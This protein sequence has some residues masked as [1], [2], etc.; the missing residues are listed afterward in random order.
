MWAEEC[1]NGPSRL[2]AVYTASGSESANARRLILSAQKQ[3]D[4][5]ELVASPLA[6]S[7]GT[8]PNLSV[9]GCQKNMNTSKTKYI[10]HFVSSALCGVLFYRSCVVSFAEFKSP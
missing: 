1:A 7:P 6:V 5:A 4:S 3:L 2:D 10:V 8:R 9:I